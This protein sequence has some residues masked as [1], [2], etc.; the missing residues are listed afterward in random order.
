MPPENTNLIKQKRWALFASFLYIPL[1]VIF[2]GYG[3][4]V[5]FME[6]NVRSLGEIF[7]GLLMI[8]SPTILACLGWYLTF[9]YHRHNKYIQD[10]PWHRVVV[11]LLMW[12]LILS[13]L[14]L[15]IIFLF[16]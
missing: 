6:S 5:S 16:S 4:L 13:Y 8:F 7:F 11:L 2:G 9:S 15:G 14:G 10:V 12:F 3:I 1:I